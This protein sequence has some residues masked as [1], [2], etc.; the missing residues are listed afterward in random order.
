[1]NRS[2]DAKMTWR[3]STDHDQL[4]F[5]VYHDGFAGVLPVWGGYHRIF[6]LEDDANTPDRDPTLE[7]MQQRAR[8]ITGTRR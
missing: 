6:I 8:K 5:F 1:M 7:E 3:R 2:I 4:W